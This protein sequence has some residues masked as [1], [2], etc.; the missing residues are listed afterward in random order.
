LRLNCSGMPDLLTACIL[1]ADGS[2]TSMSL[3]PHRGNISAAHVSMMPPMPAT[4]W[5]KASW[6][7]RKLL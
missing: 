2:G 6:N 3:K 4:G 7:P 1:T 5:I